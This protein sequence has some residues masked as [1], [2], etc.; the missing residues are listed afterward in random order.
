MTTKPRTGWI[1]PTRETAIAPLRRAL[2]KKHLRAK[3][4]G[5]RSVR[6]RMRPELHVQWVLFIHTCNLSVNGKK[7]SFLMITWAR[8]TSLHTLRP[9]ID[10]R[11]KFDCSRRRERGDRGRAERTRKA[12]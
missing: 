2:R 5:Q 8:K 3:Q 10:G 12:S 9:G 7:S 4:I 11:S 6:G 1:K